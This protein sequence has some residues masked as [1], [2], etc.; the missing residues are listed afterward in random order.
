MPSAEPGALAAAARPAR[1]GVGMCD[2]GS[3]GEIDLHELHNHPEQ[4]A[5]H[6][7]D[8]HVFEAAC[9]PLPQ[10]PHPRLLI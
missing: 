4:A 5:G 9:L 3:G 8:G 1:D 7:I 2:I 10:L 6:S